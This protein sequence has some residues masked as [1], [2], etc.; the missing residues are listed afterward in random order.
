VRPR[1]AN[2]QRCYPRC[3]EHRQHRE[4]CGRGHPIAPA[5][6]RRPERHE[7]PVPGRPHPKTRA[8]PQEPS[9]SASI[10]SRYIGSEGET[11]GKFKYYPLRR[12]GST[13]ALRYY[14]RDVASSLRHY[15]PLQPPLMKR[16]L[17]QLDAVN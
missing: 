10:A 9:D 6:G 11:V 14:P 2:C 4:L 3:T 12:I 13:N 8:T 5:N 1:V 7:V 15:A 17:R 16:D